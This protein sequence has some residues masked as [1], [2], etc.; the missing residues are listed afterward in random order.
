MEMQIWMD[1]IELDLIQDASRLGI[2]AGVTTNPKIL[3]CAHQAPETTIEKLLDVQAGAVA[4][5]VTEKALME[6]IKQA[7]RLARISDRIIVKIPAVTDGLRAIAMLEKEG[8]ATLAT[9]VYD[10]R[11][12]VFAGIAGARYA[13]PYIDKIETASGN[14]FELLR[15]AQHALAQL[16]C[17]TQIMGAALKSVHQFTQCAELG[18]GAVTLPPPVYQ[19]LFSTSPE[20]DASLAAFDTAWGANP[21]TAQSRLFSNP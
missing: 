14:A 5:Q 11:Q 7:R 4:V 18:I 15:R 12:I 13:A 21:H 6:I 2:L 9:T 17:P 1:T 20:I 3:S 8:I 10:L 16:D 19:A